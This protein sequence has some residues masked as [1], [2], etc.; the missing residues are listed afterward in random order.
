MNSAL[1]AR[2]VLLE[3]GIRDKNISAVGGRLKSFCPAHGGGAFKSLQVDSVRRTC[4]CLL[5]DCIAHEQTTL[6]GLY[7]LIRKASELA[8]ALDLAQLFKIELPAAQLRE[9]VQQN[10]NSAN[11]AEQEKDFSACA[12]FLAVAFFAE[13][14]NIG[15]AERLAT[16]RDRAGDEHGAAE[17]FLY[18]SRLARARGEL[19]R[20][21]ALLEQKAAILDP[22]NRLILMEMVNLQKERGVVGVAAKLV[23]CE[24]RFRPLIDTLLGRVI[25]VEDVQT[26][27]RMVRRALGSVVTLD[28]TYIEPTGVI[29][30]GASSADEGV[31]SRQRELDELPEQIAAVRAK[32]DVSKH[33]IETARQAVTQLSAR[34]RDADQRYETIRRNL[35]GA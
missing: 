19:K 27:L 24:Q 13:P 18:A 9:I 5:K 2:A 22:E 35:D 31:F 10:I 12:G 1:D 32:A 26:G 8:A 33:Q 6:V 17:A 20:A 16:M 21:S 11:S 29:T 14:H 4:H 15:F 30:G 3:L 23:R 34:A 7:A 25:V 28:G